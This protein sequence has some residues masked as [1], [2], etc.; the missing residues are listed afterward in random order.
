MFRRGI[1]IQYAHTKFQLFKQNYV[2]L[3]I[4]LKFKLSLWVLQLYKII[5]L[6]SNQE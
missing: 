6:G 2:C 1:E 3:R 5:S 4:I